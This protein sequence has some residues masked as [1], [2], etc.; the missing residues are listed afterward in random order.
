[1]AQPPLIY[2]TAVAA[3]EQQWETGQAEI[4]PQFY[5][6]PGGQAVEELLLHSTLI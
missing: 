3:R 2:N 4:S 5:E 1:M 6:T